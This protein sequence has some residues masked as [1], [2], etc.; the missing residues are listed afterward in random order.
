M[1]PLALF[2]ALLYDDNAMIVIGCMPINRANK[3]KR[4]RYKKKVLR[5]QEGK[6]KKNCRHAIVGLFLSFYDY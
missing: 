1:I 3:K 6:R 2:T 4:K 5:K